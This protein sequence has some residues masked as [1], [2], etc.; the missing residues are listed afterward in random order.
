MSFAGVEKNR[1]NNHVEQADT[2][3]A[4]AAAT[5]SPFIIIATDPIA[6]P[7]FDQIIPKIEENNPEI[8]NPGV[9]LIFPVAL[10][11]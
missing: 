7:F 11:S 9:S 10:I 5:S 3:N 1:L 8:K 4:F 6:R 2:S